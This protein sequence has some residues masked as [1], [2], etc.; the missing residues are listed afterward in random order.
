MQN[1]LVSVGT[2]KKNKF[3]GNTS[4]LIFYLTNFIPIETLSILIDEK[5]SMLK[6]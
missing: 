6:L 3:L 1:I 4:S 5:M 2:I